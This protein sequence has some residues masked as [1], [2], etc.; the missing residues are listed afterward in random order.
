MHYAAL[1][2]IARNPNAVVRIAIDKTT[3]E[4]F[5]HETMAKRCAL[6]MQEYAT[7]VNAL[8]HVIMC[9]RS[10][11]YDNNK[12]IEGST[13]NDDRQEHCKRLME[14]RQ[15]LHHTAWHSKIYEILAE[16]RKQIKVIVCTSTVA[17]Q[18][19]TGLQDSTATRNKVLRMLLWD[20]YRL[21]VTKTEPQ[22]RTL[23]L[24]TS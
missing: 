18:I 2:Q 3:G 23:F 20:E 19:A 13:K 9:F 10:Q 8:D 6:L 5:L 22:I 16:L 7:L 17:L 12:L 1:Q 15:F 11:C 24:R 14:Y 4:D 21:G